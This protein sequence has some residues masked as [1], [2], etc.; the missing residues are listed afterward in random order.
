MPLTLVTGP[1]NSAKAG[2]VLGG[3]RDRLEDEPVLVVPAFQDVEHAQR[4]LAARGAVFG[5]EELRFDRL[6]Q[7]LAERAGSTIERSSSATKRA[8]ARGNPGWEADS[9][10]TCSLAPRTASSTIS[11]L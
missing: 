6:F 7:K 4:E 11:S 8:A 3:L 10:S 2:E 9:A 1:A 5:A